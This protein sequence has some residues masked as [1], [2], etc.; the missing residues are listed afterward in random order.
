MHDCNL[1]YKN[2]VEALKFYSELRKKR[3][4]DPNS[5]PLVIISNEIDRTIEKNPEVLR[6]LP[7]SSQAGNRLRMLDYKM[8]KQK[9]RIYMKILI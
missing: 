3:R 5:M 9:V 2:S 4:Q 1:E 6:K 7:T 8:R